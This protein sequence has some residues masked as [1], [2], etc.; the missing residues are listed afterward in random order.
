MKKLFT[1]TSLAVVKR[2][3]DRLSNAIH[4][5]GSKFYQREVRKIKSYPQFCYMHG[6]HTIQ[7]IMG[8]LHRLPPPAL[9]IFRRG[10]NFV[11]RFYNERKTC[12][13]KICHTPWR[14]DTFDLTA[15][16]RLK[17]LQEINKML[18]HISVSKLCVQR[19]DWKCSMETTWNLNPIKS[20][21]WIQKLW[22][23]RLDKALEKKHINI[24]I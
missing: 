7:T 10:V 17:I 2:S 20:E 18:S 14:Y 23:R 22:S 16:I 8:E 5:K 4:F 6:K 9:L 21:K 3:W 13:L 19:V 11:G 1:Y 15:A 24:N 12:A